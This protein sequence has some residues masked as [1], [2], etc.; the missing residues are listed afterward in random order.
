M[1]LRSSADRKTEDIEAA[2]TIQK[3]ESGWKPS[4][5]DASRSRSWDGGVAV[6]LGAPFIKG[7]R[8]GLKSDVVIYLKEEVQ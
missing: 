4:S 3:R 1:Q 5:C 7:V 6:P 2:I 8:G